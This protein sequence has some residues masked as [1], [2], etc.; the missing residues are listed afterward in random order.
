MRNALFY[1]ILISLIN[2]WRRTTEKHASPN[3]IEIIET[4]Q[5][6]LKGR[7]ERVKINA[8]LKVKKKHNLIQRVT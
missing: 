4:N 5:F 3:Q 2:S 6:K 1:D 7:T 8:Q